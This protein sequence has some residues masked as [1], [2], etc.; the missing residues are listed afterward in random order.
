MIGYKSTELSTG[1]TFEPV[2]ASVKSNLVVPASFCSQRERE[3]ERERER[4]GNQ[5][6]NTGNAVPLAG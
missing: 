4:V 1:R 2:N 3:R 5:I 6:T